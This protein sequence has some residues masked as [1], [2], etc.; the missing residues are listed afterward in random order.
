MAILAFLL[1]VSFSLAF[2][3]LFYEPD[4]VSSVSLCVCVFVCVCACVHLYW[5]LL[6]N[7]NFELELREVGDNGCGNGL[8]GDN[9]CGN[10]LLGDNG[11]GNGLLGD[12]GCGNGLLG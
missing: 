3:M 1:V 10:G 9:G 5:K 4:G 12:N 2:Y 6:S 7:P 11:C 8:L